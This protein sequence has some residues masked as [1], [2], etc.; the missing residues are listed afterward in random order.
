MGLYDA[1]LIKDN[2][3]AAAGSITAA[4]TATRKAY[5]ADVWIEVEVDTR[6]QFEE[7]L[8]KGANRVLL[9]NM[10]PESVRACVESG[11]A[12]KLKQL[13]V[14][15]IEASGGIDLGNV[16]AY[17]EA[18]AEIISVGAL[19]KSAPGIDFSLEVEK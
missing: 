8:D 17:A 11:A 10:T 14:P 4:I 5:G 12:Y 13:R 16:R 7:A 9:D 19:T 6:P 3:I 18:G 2:H 1:V 15:E